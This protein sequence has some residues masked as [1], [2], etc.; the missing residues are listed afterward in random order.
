VLKNGGA[1]FVWQGGTGR[2]FQQIYARFLSPTNT[3]LTT[4]DVL[5]NSPTN[6]VS[7]SYSYTQPPTWN[8]WARTPPTP[9]RPLPR[10]LPRIDS[11]GSFRINPAVAV[12]NNSNVVVVWAS[13]NQA[14]SNSLLDVYGQVLSHRPA[15]RWRRTF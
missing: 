14:S 4:N 5:V 8:R 13:F 6:N 3:W 10:P 9:P 15:R 2:R 11:S 7:Y 1:V 12:L